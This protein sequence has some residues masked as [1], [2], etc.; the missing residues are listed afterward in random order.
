MA[1]SSTFAKAK[2]FGKR[3]IGQSEQPV[4]VVSVKDWTRNLSEN[5]VRDVGPFRL[6]LLRAVSHFDH[7]SRLYDMWSRCSPFSVGSLDT[8][9]PWSLRHRS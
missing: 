5:P 2:S 3:I 7:P 8:V 1:S 6:L 9:S 4:P